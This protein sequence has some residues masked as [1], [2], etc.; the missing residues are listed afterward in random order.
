MKRITTVCG[1]IAPENLGFTDMHEHIMFNGADMGASCRP[2]MP[3]DLPVKYEDKV[4]LENIGFLKRN[5][6]LV[7]D[8]MDLNDEEAMTREVQEYKDSGGDS[9]VELSVP[10]IRLD[11]KAVKRISQKTGVNVITA[12]GYYVESSWSGKYDGWSIRQFYDHMIDEIENGI[13]DTQIK[14]GCVK[15]ALNDFTEAEEKALRA[16][17]QAAKDTGMSIT[18]HPDYAYGGTPGEIVEILVEEGVDPEKIVIAHM[19]TT[20][21]RPMKEM[22]LYPEKWGLDLDV[23]KRV[24]DKGANFSVEFL[25][26]DIGLEALGTA[27]IP[28]WMKMAGIVRLIQQGYSRQ[29]V[30]GTDM[31]VK[32]MCRQ[33]GGEGYCRLTKFGVPALKKYGEVSDLAVRNMTVNNPARILAY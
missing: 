31:C 19:E 16:G 8:A 4:S 17:G 11:V 28:D 30:L 10:G 25:S 22:V 14:P 32:T 24:L 2:A 5:F 26:G 20:V 1:D 18:V 13:E 15:I 12:T 21:K 33:F 6:P 29:I 27:P 7:A 3:T 23:A 9:M